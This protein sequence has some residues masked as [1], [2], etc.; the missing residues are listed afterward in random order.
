MALVEGKNRYEYLLSEVGNIS[1]ELVTVTVASAA[2]VPGQVLGIVTASGKYI[3]W[4]S[5]ASDGSQN[6]VAILADHLPAGSADHKAVVHRRL[7]EVDKSLLSTTN[8]TALAGLATQ[9]IIAR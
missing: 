4:T 1:R 8:A 9:N 5:G 7:C 2:L 6:A 3:P